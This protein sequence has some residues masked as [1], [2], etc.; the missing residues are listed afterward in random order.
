MEEESDLILILLSEHFWQDPEA[1]AQFLYA[2]YSNKKIIVAKKSDVDWNALPEVEWQ[3]VSEWIEYADQKEMEEKL[4]PIL[5][6][7]NKIYI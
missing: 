6:K 5:E 4:I 3:Y 2:V 1:R 7:S